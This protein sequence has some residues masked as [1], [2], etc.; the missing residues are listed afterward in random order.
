[1]LSRYKIPERY[2]GLCRT[3]GHSW[4]EGGGGYL[5]AFY[6]AQVALTIEKS[7]LQDTYLFRL[8]ARRDFRN[9]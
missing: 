6:N 4:K 1:M 2:A 9:V 7:F 8:S 5:L 3:L